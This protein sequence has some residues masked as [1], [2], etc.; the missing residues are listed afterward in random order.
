MEQEEKLCDLVDTAME[1]TYICNRVSAGE[2]CEA[3]LTARMRCG[4]V[5]FMECSELLYGR[6]FPLRLNGTVYKSYVR[7]TML[8]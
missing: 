8:Y 1:F 5:K 2:G 4:Q 7:P 3:A 6:R